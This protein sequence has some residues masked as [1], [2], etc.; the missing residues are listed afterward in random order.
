VQFHGSGGVMAGAAFT[1]ISTSGQLLRLTSQAASDTPL[2]LRAHGGQS[3]DLQRWELSDG[4]VVSRINRFGEL[5]IPSRVPAATTGELVI[6][7]NVNANYM[8][9]VFVMGIRGVESN[10]LAWRS[11]GAL[12]FTNGIALNP[13]G[14]FMVGIS[15]MGVDYGLRRGGGQSFYLGEFDNQGV[16]SFR[17]TGG[18]Y[19]PADTI[20]HLNTS[21]A[22]RAHSRTVLTWLN[23]TDSVRRAQV[24]YE[25][26]DTGRRTL[27]RDYTDGSRAYR[28]HIVHATAPA[29]ADLSNSEVCF[30]TNGSGHLLIKLKDSGGTVRTGTITLS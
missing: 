19:Y 18:G 13:D 23:S 25:I 15:S 16:F 2:A 27:T 28:A 9:P 10:G 24:L 30:Y 7:S 1:V 4:T 6:R 22:N 8:E 5:S 20:Y 12:Q 26:Y 3:Q 29:D 14:A 17:A 11:N 21:V